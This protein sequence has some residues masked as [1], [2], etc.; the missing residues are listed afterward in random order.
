MLFVGMAFSDETDQYLVWGVELSDSADSINR[1]LN[2]EIGAFLDKKN[3][4]GKKRADDDA[5]ECYELTNDLFDHLFAHRKN[6]L[7]KRWIR[8]SE[9]VELY[10]GPS[11]RR[12]QYRNMSIMR[13]PAF[14]FI[15]P[16]A[17]TFRIGG[18]YLGLDKIGHI[19]GFGDRY[20]RRYRKHIENGLPEEEAIKKIVHWGIRQEN[21]VVGKLADG[22]FSHG[23][24]EGNYQGFLL[25]RDF[26]EGETP[27]FVQEQGTWRLTRPVDLRDYITP[28]LDESFEPSHYRGLR[29]RFVLAVL[30]DEYVPKQS[31][32]EVQARF[33]RYRQIE[34]SVS[35]RLVHEYFEER[36]RNPQKEQAN[37]WN[38]NA[39]A[40]Q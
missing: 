18:V 28:H 31:L 40:S 1:F 21:S 34:P 12:A 11:V 32:P 2:A 7:I 23:D 38:G 29:K 8:N 16:M 39:I 37:E 17:R 30:R 26:C 14:P 9:E 13:G 5:C 10:P 24:L 3:A 15:L 36:G 25:A 33:A 6:A 20:Y 22:V 27:Y 19:F 35:V 4:S